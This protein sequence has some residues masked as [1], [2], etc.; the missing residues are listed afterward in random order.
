MDRE[1]EIDDYFADH[2]ARAEDG[3]EGDN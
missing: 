2:D 1:K 3:L